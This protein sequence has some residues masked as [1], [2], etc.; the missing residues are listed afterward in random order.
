MAE[1]AHSFDKAVHLFSVGHLKL[2]HT[3]DSCDLVTIEY[4]VFFY[5][6]LPKYSLSQGIFMQ[7]MLIEN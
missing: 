7:Q 5:V 2:V 6:C 3:N 1:Q 4:V